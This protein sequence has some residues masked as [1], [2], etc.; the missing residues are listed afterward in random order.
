MSQSF[1]KFE[2]KESGATR[3]RKDHAE[4]DYKRYDA[5]YPLNC[6]LRTFMK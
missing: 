2:L 3:V 5:P 6:L 1:F 4:D